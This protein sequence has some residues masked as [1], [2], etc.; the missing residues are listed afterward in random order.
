MRYELIQNGLS[1]VL[2]DTYQCRASTRPLQL[3]F[4]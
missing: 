4:Y 3:A 1:V 2:E